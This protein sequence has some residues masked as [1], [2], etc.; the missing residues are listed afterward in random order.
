[1][2]KLLSLLV[3]L[4]AFA[5]I[6]SAQTFSPLYGTRL[7]LKN[8]SNKLR[9]YAP[10]FVSSYDLIMPTSLG[11]DGQ[12]LGITSGS[13]LGWI[14]P[15][16]GGTDD[17]FELEDDSVTND[18][19]AL[20]DSDNLQASLDASSNYAIDAFLYYR[21]DGH[22]GTDIRTAF[23]YT[24]TLTTNGMHLSGRGAGDA[25]GEEDDWTSSGS[26]RTINVN[27]DE[28]AYIHV[29]GFIR[30][31][32]SGTFKVQFANGSEG[33]GRITILKGG[34]YMKITKF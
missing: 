2:K 13:Q 11:T 1:M 23:T 30:T 8:G 32:T 29:V 18:D 14:T 31:S 17:L 16:V 27:Q 12:V 15:S 22:D 7:E 4:V 10:T 19:D 28:D 33:S 25:E 6:A 21:T 34:S 20:Y 24:G 26:S 5:T 3:T 9:I